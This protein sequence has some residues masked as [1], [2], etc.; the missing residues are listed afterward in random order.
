LDVGYDVIMLSMKSS[1]TQVQTNNKEHP[2]AILSPFCSKLSLHEI[3]GKKQQRD[4]TRSTKNINSSPSKRHIIL[5]IGA[6]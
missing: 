1:I 2:F 6:L 3:K 4:K 5:P